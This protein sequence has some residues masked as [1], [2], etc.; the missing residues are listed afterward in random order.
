MYFTVFTPTYNR[1][2]ILGQAYQSLLEQTCRDF[3]W[4]IMDDGS[5]DDTEALVQG[6]IRE[7]RIN[8]KYLKQENQGRFVAYNRAVPQAE[9]EIFTF[10]DSDDQLDPEALSEL[11]KIWESV[12]DKSKYSGILSYTKHLNGEI[13]G[14]RFPEGLYAERLY[15]L[16]DKYRLKGDKLCAFRVDLAKKYRYPE[17]PG[18]KFG[19]DSIVMNY[20]N[21]EAPMILCR[22]ALCFR[23]YPFD[24]IT[25]NLKKH[26]ANSPNGQADYFR[27]SLELDSHQKW[28]LFKHAVGYVCASRMAG[29]G[30]IIAGSPKKLL[31]VLAYIPGLIYLHA[32][33][34]REYHK[35]C[36][37]D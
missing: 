12:E 7:N 14:N 32:Y 18:E 28:R 36:S 9:G 34:G 16:Y 30:R 10:L 4:L 2:Y 15:V 8:I 35:K 24:S 25:L 17:Y 13:I 6:W 27:Q 3:L 21:Q 19:G 29:R 31:T 22:R 20:I 1:A 23:E 5:Q 37:T 33:F 26:K 11:K